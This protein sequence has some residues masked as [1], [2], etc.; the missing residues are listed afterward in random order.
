MLLLITFTY[1][2][3]IHIDNNINHIRINCNNNNNIIQNIN[4][5][6]ITNNNNNN[7]NH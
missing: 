2:I 4:N 5:N 1:I 7:N 3:I 6:V